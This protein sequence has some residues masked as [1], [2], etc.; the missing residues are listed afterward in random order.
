[1]R[2][3][4]ILT[5]KKQ[6]QALTKEE[7]D[8]V[9][10]GY[11]NGSIPDY[12][13]SALLMAIYLNGMNANETSWLTMAMAYSGDTVDLSFLK[14][15]V[16]D[17]HSTGGVGD[18]TTL[19]IAPIVAA[20]GVPIAKMSGRGLGHTGGTVDKLESI[21]GFKTNLT[22]E[23]FLNLVKKT[24]ICIA[25]QSGNLAP[26]DKKIYALRDVTATVESIPLIAAS[27]MSKKIA[28]GADK[29]LL[30]VKVGSGA[31][32][33]NLDEARTLAKTMINI[34]TNCGRT[35]IA[36]LTDMSVPLGRAIGNSLEI[37]E[38]IEILSN[39][40][41]DDLREICI[42]LSSYMLR[43]AQKGDIDECEAIVRDI[44]ESG[45]GLELFNNMIKN[46]GG[47]LTHIKEADIVSS[48]VSAQTGY[49]YE[50]NTEGLGTSAMLL[51]AGRK[52]ANDTIDYSAGIILSKKTGDYVQKGQEIARLYTS[53]A[54]KIMDAKEKLEESIIFNDEPPKKKPII[55]EVCLPN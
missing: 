29:I 24:G 27:I 11:T 51:G 42:I 53:C 47:D 37:K 43:L 55:F 19:I 32:M 22:T 16:V 30:D 39:K 40:G 12:Q 3:Y 50:M 48:F 2:I 5:K 45:K 23:E 8:F 26:A 35:T 33:K 36:L 18:K 28:A 41:S 34:G 14:D 17:K 10:N 46:Q 52:T 25:G 54:S 9:I 20:A 38:A 21:P 31:F 49:I 13:M 15:N 4:D 7:I 44:I 1:M 6:A